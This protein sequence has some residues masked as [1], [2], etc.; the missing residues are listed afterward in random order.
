MTENVYK[1]PKWSRD[2]LNRM[3][4]AASVGPKDKK[5]TR[6]LRDMKYKEHEH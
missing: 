1:K 5:T 6:K 2:E 4:L 3:Y